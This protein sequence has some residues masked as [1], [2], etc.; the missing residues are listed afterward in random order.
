M[1]SFKD[2]VSTIEKHNDSGSS[3]S[4]DSLVSNIEKNVEQNKPPEE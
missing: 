2:G 1:T 4:L 3:E